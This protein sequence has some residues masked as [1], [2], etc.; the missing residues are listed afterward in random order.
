MTTQDPHLTAPENPLNAMTPE[1]HATYRQNL[2]NTAAAQAQ[3]HALMNPL[4]LTPDTE[5]PPP[6]KT[7][8]ELEKEKKDNL[9]EYEIVSIGDFLQQTIEEP[10]QLIKNLL[11]KGDEMCVGSGSKS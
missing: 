1:E 9:Q 8:Q 4:V 10:K 7:A 2:K 5:P 6:T 11:Y 3:Q